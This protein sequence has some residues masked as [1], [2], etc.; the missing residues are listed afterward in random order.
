VAGDG[1]CSIARRL[2]RERYERPLTHD[3]LDEAIRRL[4]GSVIQ[5]EVG[6]LRDST[7][8]ATLVLWDGQ[9]QQRI[10]ARSS[11]AIAVALGHGAPI[12]VSEAVVTRTGVPPTAF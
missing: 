3:L 6:E 7:F 10:D 1:S 9:R 12:Y 2:A 4:G 11:D 5:V 8:I